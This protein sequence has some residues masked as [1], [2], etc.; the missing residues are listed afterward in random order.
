MSDHL[1]DNAIVDLLI[2][3]ANPRF[4]NIAVDRK[5][6]LI[7]DLDDAMK[8]QTRGNRIAAIGKNL[9][10]YDAI[11]TGLF[12]CP[13]EIF[14]YLEQAKSG[15]GRSDCSLANEFRWWL[16][17]T[18]SVRLISAARGGTTSILRKCCSMPRKT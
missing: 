10:T 4:L 3:S 7:Y 17:M 11:D 15:S 16:P 14:D 12:V 9:R 2:D 6:D 18:K 5:L 1:F 13:L 8:V